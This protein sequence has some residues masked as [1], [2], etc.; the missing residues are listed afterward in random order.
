MSL[1][2]IAW[3]SLLAMI[4][5]NSIPLQNVIASDSVATARV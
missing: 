1:R 4:I 2:A 5:F 3:Q